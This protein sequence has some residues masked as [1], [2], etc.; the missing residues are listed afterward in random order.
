[1]NNYKIGIIGL[2]YVG[3]AVHNFFKEFYDINT[4]HTNTNCNQASI[5]ELVHRSNIIFLCLPTPMNKDGSTHLDILSN[6]ISEIDEISIDKN[7]KPYIVIKSTIP[8]GTTHSYINKYDNISILFNPEFLRE[9]SFNE[10][11][12]NQKRIILGSLDDNTPVHRLYKECFTSSEICNTN[13]ST[14]ELV[15]YTTNCFLATKVSF[16]NEIKSFCNAK[17]INYEDVIKLATMDKRLGSSHWSVPGPDG[18]N[19][20]GGSCFPKDIASL[21]EQFQ[22]ENIDS[23]VIKSAWLRNTQIDRPD[24][25]WEKLKKRAVI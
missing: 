11:F 17:N 22:I 2:G 7:N 24:R 21:I 8:V 4:F 5:K 25:D 9:A 16:A 18:K 20:F 23:Y 12:K 14:A 1:M 10:D 13:P 3:Y 19:G 15:K 6:V